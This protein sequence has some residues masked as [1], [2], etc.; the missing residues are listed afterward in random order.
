[1]F[2][3]CAHNFAHTNSCRKSLPESQNLSM[4]AGNPKITEARCHFEDRNQLSLV[5]SV[6]KKSFDPGAQR[7]WLEFKKGNLNYQ[8][9]IV[10]Y[11]V[12]KP[13]RTR[14]HV[15]SFPRLTGVPLISELITSTP[16]PSKRA[17][18]FSLTWSCNLK[19]ALNIPWIVLEGFEL[20]LW[21]VIT[22]GC[23]IHALL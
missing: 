19:R 20:Q 14:P 11:P 13:S 9:K 21:A 1:M 17:S 16:C 2:I 4:C 6:G 15:Y 10:G 18:L 23:H 8:R 22:H 12:N 5:P 3:I 7:N